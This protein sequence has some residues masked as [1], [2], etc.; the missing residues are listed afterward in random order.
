MADNDVPV[1]WPI[2]TPGAWLSC[3]IKRITEHCY[4]QDIKARGLKVFEKRAFVCFSHCKY[5]GANDPQDGAIFDPRDMIGRIYVEHHITY[6]FILNIQ[7]LGLQKRRFFHIS[8]I[9][10]IFTPRVWPIWTP[11]TW[12]AGFIKGT[13]RHCYTQNIKA[14]GYVVSEIFLYF[15]PLLSMWELMTLGV[16]P[17]LTPGA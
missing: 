2:W 4:T 7:A 9:W 8:P 11:G 14:L 17:F 6:C 5:M 3:C 15:F 10:Q 12:L 13:T 1:G 16:G